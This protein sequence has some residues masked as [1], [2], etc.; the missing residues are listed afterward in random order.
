MT[1]EGRSWEIGPDEEN[2]SNELKEK[3]T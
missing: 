2:N 3:K 1:W